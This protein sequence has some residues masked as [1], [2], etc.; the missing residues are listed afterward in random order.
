MHDFEIVELIVRGEMENGRERRS[1]RKSGGGGLSEW[2]IRAMGDSS[3]MPM[4]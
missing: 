3:D 4:R 1:G 2:K